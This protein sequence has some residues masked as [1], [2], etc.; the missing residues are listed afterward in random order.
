MDAD[1]RFMREALAEARAAAEAGEVPI[2]AVVVFEGRVIARAHNRRELDEDPSA[3]AEFSAMVAAAH[4][5][6]RWRL[7]GCTVYVTLEPCTMCAGLMVNARI[8]RCVYGATDPKAG[9]VGSLYD[10]SRDSRLNHAFEVRSG[11][12]EQECAEVL[13]TFFAAARTRELPR[14]TPDDVP[15]ANDRPSSQPRIPQPRVLLALDS[16]KGSAQSARVEAWVQEGVERACPGVRVRCLP[17]ADGGEGTLEAIGATLGGIEQTASVTGPLGSPV[18]A[19]YLQ[20]A[21]ERGDIAVIEMAEAAGIEY[22]PRTQ[23]A[24]LRATTRGVG[25]LLLEALKAGARTVYFAIGGS[26]TSDGGAGFLQALGA[27]LLDERGEQIAP[28]LAGLADLAHIDIAPALKVLTGCRLVVLSDVDN[29][30]VGARGAV[31]TFGPQKGLGSDAANDADR[32]DILRKLDARMV[33]Y[34]R[35][36]D[37]ARGG[38]CLDA[39]PPAR[40]F[41]SVL[42]VP[43]AGAAG[44][45]GAALLALGAQMVPGG[46]AV[47]DLVGFDEAVANADLVITGEGMID[48]Q[49][50][51]GKAPVAVARRAKRF[52]KPVVALGGGRAEQLEAVYA[53]GVDLVLPI[54]RAPMSLAQALSPEETRRNLICAGEEALRAYL[55]RNAH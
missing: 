51:H 5:L 35:R 15:R 27:Q 6:G 4:A 36:L 32:T 13:R 54:V 48:A 26:A 7:T 37:A 3:H 29:P 52:H 46:N 43:G 8:D 22:S 28:G 17:I 2:G 34:G 38:V 47:L 25:E 45:L 24:A 41:R 21:G 1:E 55:L 49:T 18:R 30:L 16:F 10:L 9:A 14:E 44:G 12:L 53:E 33:A 31:C 20:G 19:R 42:G 11:V 23:S 39:E 40:R 50:A